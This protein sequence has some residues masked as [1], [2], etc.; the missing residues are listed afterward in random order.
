MINI[1]KSLVSISLQNPNLILPRL[2]GDGV[3]SEHFEDYASRVIFELMLKQRSAKKDIE[4]ISLTELLDQNGDLE[5][6][7]GGSK[8]AEIYTYQTTSEHYTY[9]V[10][11]LKQSLAKRRAKYALS[12]TDEEIRMMSAESL[13]EHLKEASQSVTEAHEDNNGSKTA[14]QSCEEFLAAFESQMQN[15]E[16]IGT[17]TGLQPLD[18][19]TNG[20]R[21]GEL[22]ILAAPTSGGKSVLAL[23]LALSALKQKKK[24][25]IFSLEMGAE[26]NIARMISASQSVHYENLRKPVGLKKEDIRGIQRGVAELSK[27]DLT[28]C[29]EAGLTIERISSVAQRWKDLKGLDLL[30]VDYVQLIKSNHRKGERTDEMLCR[31]SGDLKQLAKALKCVVI[32]ASQLN[33]EGRMAQASG[34]ANDADVVLRIEGDEGVYVLKNRNGVKHVH[35]PLY[36]QGE[37]Q[38]FTTQ[39]QQKIEHYNN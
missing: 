7:G 15:K 28:I 6:I 24:T 1:E 34:I 39:K 21:A 9:H 10:E 31:I 37:Y 22:W 4:L 17:E 27:L 35:L 16:K 8:V 32:T 30:V 33:S 23:Q 29:D 38:R 18:E 2:L 11:L 3:N 26:E 13:A 19:V 20:M 14:K 36:M 12:L 5:K 25:G